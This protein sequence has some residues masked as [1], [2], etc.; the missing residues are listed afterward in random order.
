MSIAENNTIP[1]L[2]D[3]TPSGKPGEKLGI[4]AFTAG[5]AVSNV[6]EGSIAAKASG[7]GSAFV[8]KHTPGGNSSGR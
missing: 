1:L 7:G 8:D 6:A 2:P 3:G 4:M 5:A